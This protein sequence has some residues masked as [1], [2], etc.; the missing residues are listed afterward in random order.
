[1]SERIEKIIENIELSFNKL[2]NSVEQ[3]H[4]AENIASSSVVTTSTLITEFKTSI[5]VIEKLVKNDFANE[6][7]KLADL[8]IILLEKISKIDFE[9]KFQFIEQKINDKNFD[10]NFS[11]LNKVVSEINFDNKFQAIEQKINDKNFN[12]KFNELNTI[13]SK[14]NFDNKFQ[15]IEEI[16]DYQIKE[17][18][19]LKMLI[20]IAFSLIII[21]TISIIILPKI[22]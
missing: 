14:I 17:I 11:E 9:K 8:N 15:T 21:C 4:K 16:L 13:I 5:E 3:L 6:Y 18:Q 20:Y 19:Q 22:I 2:N 12:S 10:S 7:N 1:M